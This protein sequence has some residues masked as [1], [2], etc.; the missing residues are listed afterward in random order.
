ML[1]EGTAVLSIGCACAQQLGGLFS[2]LYFSYTEFCTQGGLLILGL[3][4]GV[5]WG[6]RPEAQGRD[7][8]VSGEDP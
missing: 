8:S 4:E 2:I 1:S 7:C 3:N 5:S 6:F